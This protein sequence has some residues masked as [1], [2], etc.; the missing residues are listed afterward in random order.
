MLVFLILVPVFVVLYLRMQRRRSEIAARYGSMGFVQQTGR[1]VLGWR[2]HLP[3]ILFLVG[4]TVM[5]LAMARPEATVRLPRLTGTVILTFDVSGSMA[6]EDLKP[7]RMEA[8][9][10]AARNFVER[11]PTSVQIGVVAFS[12]SGL[13]VQPPTND[14]ELIFSTINRLGPALGTSLSQGIYA[15]LTAIFE[16][17]KEPGV[18]YSDLTPTPTSVPSPVPP[19]SNRSAAI[20]LLSDGENTA[21]PDPFEAVQ[22]AADRGVRIYTIGVGSAKGTPLEING[23]NVV[24]RLDETTLKQIAQMTEGEYYNAENEEDLRA[25]YDT[26][27]PELVM[28]SE[29]MEVTSLFAG[30]SIL[31]LLIA[32]TMS[33]LWFGRIP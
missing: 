17:P 25:I 27:T 3:P 6:A 2:R 14:R 1:R 31:I 22:T 29:K 8:S 13:M 11:Q 4:L 32:G 18:V 20:V 33:M 16:K 26:L 10:A 7:N 21:P 15:S 24:T 9:K 23:I 28:K 12:D 19:G 30:A 5:L